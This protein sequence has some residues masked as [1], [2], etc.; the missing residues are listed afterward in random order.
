VRCEQYTIV[1]KLVQGDIYRTVCGLSTVQE[2]RLQ[3]VPVF[4]GRKIDLSID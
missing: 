1:G 4:R 3:D 2:P